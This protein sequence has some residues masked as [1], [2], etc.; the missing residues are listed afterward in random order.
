MLL[1]KEADCR[2]KFAHEGGNYVMGK[3]TYRFRERLLAGFL[4][5]MCVLSL[6]IGTAPQAFAEPQEG[7]V[8]NIELFFTNEASDNISYSE[9]GKKADFS[10]P[11]TEQQVNVRLVVS[12]NKLYQKGQLRVEVPYRAFQKRDGS[13]SFMTNKTAFLNQIND[14][15]ILTLLEDNSNKS[16]EDGVI[17]LTNKAASAPQIVLNLSYTVKAWE[18]EDNRTHDFGV[19]IT[20]T[21]SGEDRSP[22]KLTATFRTHVKSARVYKYT[23]SNGVTSGCYYT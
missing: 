4:S 10:I 3:S 19:K 5:L 20:D 12:L 11:S 14:G 6:V 1:W 9:D 2:F 21:I 13:Y 23:E 15:S 22:D 18:T 8:E 17:V 7:Y 16:G